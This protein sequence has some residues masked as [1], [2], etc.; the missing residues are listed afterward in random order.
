V[1]REELPAGVV[2][3]PFFTPLP[4]PNGDDPL[5]PWH[6]RRWAI[7]LAVALLAGAVLTGGVVAGKLWADRAVADYYAA[8]TQWRVGGARTFVAAVTN[9]APAAAFPGPVNTQAQLEAQKAGCASIAQTIKDLG[10]A[11]GRMPRLKSVPSPLFEN[12]T[13]D[14]AYQLDSQRHVVVSALADAAAAAYRQSDHDCQWSY[15]GGANVLGLLP[16]KAYGESLINNRAAGVKE[17]AKAYR[18]YDLPVAQAMV[19]FFSTCETTSLRPACKAYQA[20][21]A[22]QLLKMTNLV[23]AFDSASSFQD[24][25]LIAAIRAVYPDK[26]VDTHLREQIGIALPA[27]KKAALDSTDADRILAFL[28][29]VRVANLTTQIEAVQRL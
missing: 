28:A 13:Y 16:K 9:G 1:A 26:P 4:M 7:V 23:N 8:F 27:V 20:D 2:G 25:K 10:A 21:A 18:D 19:A 15:D 14:A 24:P 12:G 11:P 17:Y 5:A 3:H 6:R 22:D 29:S